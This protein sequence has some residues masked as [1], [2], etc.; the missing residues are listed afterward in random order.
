ML[1]FTEGRF[2]V[3]LSTTIIESG[4]DIPTANT[5]LV[6][7]ADQY[8]LAQLYQLRGRVGRSRERGYTYLLVAS[9]STLSADARKR[10]AV[11]QKF[12]ELGSGFHVASHDMELRGAG[13][14]LG[15]KQKGQMQAVGLELYAQLLEEAVR[16]LRGETP[17]VEFDP[18]INLQVNARLPEDFV[19]DNHL[20]LVLYKRLAN[21]NDEEDVLAV[22]E[23]MVDRFGPLPR[24]VE[25]LVEVMRVRTLA[26]YVG[27]RAVDLRG[28]AL[29]LTVH[30]ETPMPIPAIIGLVSDPHSGFSAPADLKLQYRFDAHERRDT[31]VA[32][33]IALQRLAEL[34]TEALDDEEQ[35]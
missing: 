17:P 30:P 1:D 12:T 4:I 22:S 19:P 14:L 20:R 13:E 28:E 11:I 21:A 32:A 15:T 18:D 33:R 29:L 5:M 2:N 3:L 16:T 7:H 25:N 24:V 9:E 8:G 6:D 27:L 34:V 10:L 26:R 23:E 31:V 35:P